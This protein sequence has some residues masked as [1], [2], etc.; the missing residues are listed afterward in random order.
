MIERNNRPAAAQFVVLAVE[1]KD[2]VYL[3]RCPLQKAVYR[4]LVL[5]ARLLRYHARYRRRS[6]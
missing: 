1:C 4:L 3:A 6:T 2:N 5:A